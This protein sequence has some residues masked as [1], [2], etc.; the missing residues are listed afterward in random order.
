MNIANRILSELNE[1]FVVPEFTGDESSVRDA[2]AY[3]MTRSKAESECFWRIAEQLEYSVTY[4]MGVDSNDPSMELHFEDGSVLYVGNSESIAFQFFVYEVKDEK[5]LE[6]EAAWTKTIKAFVEIMC[7]E[8]NYSLLSSVVIAGVKSHFIDVEVSTAQSQSTDDEGWLYTSSET[9]NIHS[10][11]EC[12]FSVSVS[13]DSDGC[14]LECSAE[15]HQ[16]NTTSI[17]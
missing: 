17:A 2:D 12:I 7:I 16:L 14:G 6:N 1:A 15:F 5:R 4:P 11:G 9:L 8:H 10:N 3:Q 13:Y